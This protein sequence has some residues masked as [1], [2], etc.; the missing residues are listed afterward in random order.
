MAAPKLTQLIAAQ[1][2]ERPVG[3]AVLSVERH[4]GAI[5]HLHGRH[6][7]RAWTLAVRDARAAVLAGHYQLMIRSRGDR[8][9]LTANLTPASAESLQA[10]DH[11]GNDVLEDLPECSDRARDHFE[12]IHE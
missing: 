3:L 2:S 5:S 6:G 12:G 4:A 8:V 11:L 10:L 7:G 1:A 9:A